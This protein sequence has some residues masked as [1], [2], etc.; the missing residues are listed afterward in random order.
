M[1]LLTPQARDTLVQA[2]VETLSPTWDK[3][4]TEAY[5]IKQDIV[6]RAEQ[7]RN[8]SEEIISVEELQKYKDEAARWKKACEDAAT[9]TSTKAPAPKNAK[10]KYW[11]KEARKY[12]ELYWEANEK[13][14]DV[15]P[16][17][18]YVD[19]IRETTLE[20]QKLT[21]DNKNLTEEISQFKEYKAKLSKFGQE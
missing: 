18:E 10:E 9:S 8:K 3:A 7:N 16:C 6:S 4:L 15:A 20:N 12:Q 14:K 5:Q 1:L 11:E 21:L 2:L 17:A 13:Y 19:L